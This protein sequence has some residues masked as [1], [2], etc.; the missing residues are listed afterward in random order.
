[1]ARDRQPQRQYPRTARV[2]ELVRAGE[3]PLE[4]VALVDR[5]F[6]PINAEPLQRR[7]NLLGVMLFRALDVRVFDAKDE[8][9][10]VPAAIEPVEERCP[11][12][13]DVEVAGGAGRKAHA[14][15]LERYAP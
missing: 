3:I 9:A 13:A 8:H 4:A 5:S 15:E 6:I 14:H 7:D 1:M 11:R 2:N 12:V 10:A